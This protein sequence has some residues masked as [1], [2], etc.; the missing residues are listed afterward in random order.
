MAANSLHSVKS[1]PRMAAWPSA[2]PHRLGAQP[3]P[4]SAGRGALGEGGAECRELACLESRD[5]P[6]LEPALSPALEVITVATDLRR[7]ACH[8][9][10]G[11]PDEHV[12]D[13]RA[14]AVDQSRDHPALEVVE[15]PPGERKACIGEF[16]D[17]RGEVE[18]AI[19]PGLYDV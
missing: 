1:G 8:P 15:A 7:R 9:V 18:L 6:E 3:P 16:R 12:D 13:V 2:R 10:R 14:P 17:R 5:G 19:E 4:S 11:R